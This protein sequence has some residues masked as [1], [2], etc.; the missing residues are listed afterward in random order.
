MNLDLNLFAF[1]LPGILTLPSITW[2]HFFYMFLFN[3]IVLIRNISSVLAIVSYMID[4]F[5]KN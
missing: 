2:E 3:F 4:F 5:F 1:F